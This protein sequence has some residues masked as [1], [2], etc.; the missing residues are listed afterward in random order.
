MQS[1]MTSKYPNLFSTVLLGLFAVAGVTGLAEAREVPFSAHSVGSVV[2]PASAHAADLDGDGD[3]EAVAVLVWNGGG[4][5]TFLSL[6]VVEN[7]NGFPMHRSTVRLVDVLEV[8]SLEIEGR[9][10]VA[11]VLEPRRPTP[12]SFTDPEKTHRYVWADGDFVEIEGAT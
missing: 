10:I 8:R 12:R 11:R 5:G 6:A 2:G 3:E 1:S 4:S 9:E 7:W